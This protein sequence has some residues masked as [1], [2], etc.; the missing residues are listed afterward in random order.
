[1]EFTDTERLVVK[2]MSAKF[3]HDVADLERWIVARKTS[4]RVLEPLLGRD[5]MDEFEQR[6]TFSQDTFDRLDMLFEDETCRTD[7]CT[8]YA[9]D[10]EGWNGYCGNCADTLYG[11]DDAA[12]ED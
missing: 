11:D 8:G 5:E 7:G 4:N 2:E 12:E 1:M 3:E 6:G 9:D 10:G